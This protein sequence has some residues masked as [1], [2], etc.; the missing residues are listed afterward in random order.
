M[1]MKD[2][3]EFKRDGKHDSIKFAN[4]KVNFFWDMKCGNKCS[5]YKVKFCIHSEWDKNTSYTL[6]EIKF[7]IQSAWDKTLHILL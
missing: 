1:N 4:R 7:C 5:L 2:L 3:Q 6:Y